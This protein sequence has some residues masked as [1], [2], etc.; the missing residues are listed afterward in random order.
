M[1]SKKMKYAS[2]AG[3]GLLTLS[4][5][6]CASE[7]EKPL[8]L[9]DKMSQSGVQKIE[10][11]SVA[12]KCKEY[13]LQKDGSYK[14]E[15]IKSSGGSS[16]GSGFSSALWFFN[17]MMFGS[18][19]AMTSSSDYKANNLVSGTKNSFSKVNSA[20]N[21]NSKTSSSSSSSKSSSSSSSKSGGFGSGGR[22]TSGGS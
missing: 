7:P 3:A 6:G 10:N 20:T 12:E 1:T 16:G 19:N 15:P 14:C 4:L 2:L 8:T 17:G 13:E 18:H 22:G 21:S 9:G 5:V 11:S